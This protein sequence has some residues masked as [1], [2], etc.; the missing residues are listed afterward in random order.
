MFTKQKLAI[1]I[2]FMLILGLFSI[3]NIYAIDIAASKITIGTGGGVKHFYL[4][5]SE[6]W[7]ASTEQEWISVSPSS[8]TGSP[9]KTTITVTV[10]AGA[11]IDSGIITFTYGRISVDVQVS[12][13]DTNNY[14]HDG[15]LLTTYQ[16]PGLPD[17]L[18]PIAIVIVGDGWDLSDLKHDGLFEQ[19]ARAWTDWF[20]EFDVV[21]D[22][23]SY[24][25]VYAYVAESEQRG[26]N[27]FAKFGTLAGV[28][29]PDRNRMAELSTLAIQ[30]VYPDVS[31][32]VFVNMANGAI[33]GWNYGAYNPAL[34][35]S[36]CQFADY[37]NPSMESHDY[38]WFNHE[39]IGHNVA[40]MPDFYYINR[41]A[42][43]N[44]AMEAYTFPFRSGT[45]PQYCTDGYDMSADNVYSWLY[46]EWDKGYYWMCDYET[47]PAAVL[48]KD[49]IGKPGYNNVGIYG[50]QTLGSAQIT[51]FKQPEE[52]NNMMNNHYSQPDV[53]TRF[54]VWNK[55]KERAGVTSSPCLLS[56]PDS[57]HPRSLYN[58][59]LWDAEHSYND[60]GDFY[61]PSDV[62]AVLTAEY[63]IQHDLLPG[64]N[65]I[66]RATITFDNATSAITVKWGDSFLTENSDYAITASDNGN[67]KIITGTGNYFGTVRVRLFS[68]VVYYGNGHTGNMLPADTVPHVSGEMVTVKFTP[69]PTKTSS[70]FAG[71]ART[72]TASVAEYVSSGNASVIMPPSGD[73]SLY[74]VWIYNGLFP[75]DQNWHVVTNGDSYDSSIGMVIDGNHGT[76][77]HSIPPHWSTDDLSKSFPHYIIVDMLHACFVDSLV[78]V[79]PSD[80]GRWTDVSV[81]MTNNTIDMTEANLPEVDA[82]H[83][84]IPAIWE[85]PKAYLPNCDDSGPVSLNFTTNNFCRYLIAVFAGSQDG[86]NPHVKV[87]ELEIFHHDSIIHADGIALNYSS[88]AKHTESD[89]TSLV[90]TVTPGNASN[91]MVSWLSANPAVA[92]VNDIGKVNFTGKGTTAII[93]TTFDGG[94]SDTCNVVV[95]QNVASV[96]LYPEAPAVALDNTLQ[97]SAIVYPSDASIKSIVFS[98]GNENIATVDASTGL[99]TAH[100][101]GQANIK[102]EVTDSL[103]N[104]VENACVVTVAKTAINEMEG[105]SPCIYPN[106]ASG[107][108]RISNYELQG[109]EIVKIFNVMG[110]AVETYSQAVSHDGAITLDVSTLPSGIYVLKIGNYKGKFVK[111]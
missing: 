2:V 9:N 73:V 24:F 103:N 41:E 97:L 42:D 50:G 40:H 5:S 1:S 102:V 38:P 104:T 27:G 86:A 54:W 98:S 37:S 14:W 20:F 15:D 107:Q 70:T 58:F 10:Q 77:W 21:R 95:Y 31:E 30:E 106:P 3:S 108:L 56:N 6:A 82:A 29:G 12:R 39:F 93:A 28:A 100:A 23:K 87:A 90:A 7:T 109:G 13:V 43:W 63:W 52:G 101:E 59:M 91:K 84:G 64:D 99:L 62:P 35:N 16:S 71:W 26:I 78:I 76:R 72:D 47:D 69:A 17:S 110:Q 96:S 45:R 36:H 44:G 18:K 79:P 46:S 32:L 22:M 111:E 4:T 60:D 85:A 61:N 49:F 67:Y 34:P 105:T 48:W 66:G 33:G 11:A 19:Y 8:G 57:A 74:A 94:Y 65:W 83:G 80:G 92:A 75:T 89:T 81:Y 55:I 25:N 51:G 88:L 53:G 68:T